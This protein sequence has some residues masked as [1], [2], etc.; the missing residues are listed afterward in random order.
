M[1]VAVISAVPTCGKSTLIEVLGGV[2]SRSQGREVVVFSTGDARENI[3]IVSNYGSNTNLDNPYIIKSMVENA[4][5]DKNELLNYGIQAG[6]EHVFIF[7]IMNSVMPKEDKEEFLL[8]AIKTIPADL[9]LIEI[10]GDVTDELN[11]KVMNLCDC[12]IVLTD[13]SQKGIKAL[14]DVTKKLPAGNMQLNRAIVLS[15]LNPIVVSDKKFSEK[16][17][18]KMVN[19][20]KFPYSPIVGKLAFDGEL[21]KICY[22]ILVG[23]HEVVNFRAP[24]QELMEFLFDTPK[25]KI[26]RSIDRW[27]R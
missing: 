3:S 1:K 4:G 14:N 6:D 7:D 15:R 5:E 2:Y 8:N 27:Y 10:C 25:R 24:I 13:P 11:K 21:D 16:S 23:E 19:I 12:S 22:N 17:G 9:T 20:F 26:I 18:L